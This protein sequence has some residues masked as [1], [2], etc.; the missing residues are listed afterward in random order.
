MQRDEEKSAV[1]IPV[2]LRPCVT[3]NA[4][5]MELQGLPKNLKPVTKWTNKDEAFTNIAK[6]IRDVANKIRTEGIHSLPLHRSK[7]TS[8]RLFSVPFAEEQFIGREQELADLNKLFLNSKKVALT[9]LGGV[10]KPAWPCVMPIN[11]NN[12]MRLFYGCRLQAK[13]VLTIA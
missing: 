13:P 8:E 3:G 2:L 7:T 6:D 9:G 10:G 1:V 5:F 12:V 11:K 4:D